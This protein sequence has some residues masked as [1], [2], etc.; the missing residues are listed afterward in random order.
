MFTYEQVNVEWY[1]LFLFLFD[2]CYAAC[3]ARRII[4]PLETWD[5]GASST[6][7]KGLRGSAGALLGPFR[8]RGQRDPQRQVQAPLS[9]FQLVVRTV[10]HG[11]SQLRVMTGES[12]CLRAP[13][14]ASVCSSAGAP[15]LCPAGLRMLSWVL[16]QLGRYLYTLSHQFH[17]HLYSGRKLH[18]HTC[19]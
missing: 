15:D 4:C 16:A 7:S 19:F 2:V 8:A 5:L 12:T 10:A 1:L 13:H 3:I 6:S 11:F 17:Q 18:L 14:L 9:L